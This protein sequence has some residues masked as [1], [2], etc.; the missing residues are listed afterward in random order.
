[1]FYTK[2]AEHPA[3]MQGNSPQQISSTRAEGV[4]RLQGSEYARYFFINRCA[5]LV[6]VDF[7]NCINYLN[8]NS[9][10]NTAKDT[11]LHRRSLGRNRMN[12]VIRT[13]SHGQWMSPKN[14]SQAVYIKPQ[15]PLQRK[16]LNKFS[17]IV[18]FPCH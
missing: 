4:S 6:V 15:E 1:M 3:R 17:H 16:S 10:S 7:H 2:V 13:L 14:C 18:L 12:I 5:Y 11:E 8:K 9:S